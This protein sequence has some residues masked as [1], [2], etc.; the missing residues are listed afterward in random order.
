MIGNG[1]FPGQPQIRLFLALADDEKM[2]CLLQGRRQGRQRLDGPV[3]ALG[4]EIGADH[5]QEIVT[6][7]QSE[8]GP[9]FFSVFRGQAGS[10][11][12]F[13]DAGRHQ[14]K[15]L[16]RG[17]VLGLIDLF[18]LCRQHDDFGPRLGPEHRP[19]KSG[20]N[21]V[22]AGQFR[23]ERALPPDAGRVTD[24]GGIVEI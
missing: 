6:R 2:C 22:A 21:P 24:I 7:G 20:K 13:I 18:F 12:F 9:D 19:F 5:E 4:M 16:I 1:Q 10:D 14:V 23:Q 15:P 8:P 11:R 17:L 3:H